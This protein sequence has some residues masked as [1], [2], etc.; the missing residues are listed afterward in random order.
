MSDPETV[1]YE[2]VED[3]MSARFG[4]AWARFDAQMQVGIPQIA[5]RDVWGKVTTKLGPV[6]SHDEVRHVPH[7]RYHV[8]Y[9]RCVFERGAH[10]LRI[11]IEGDRIAGMSMEHDRGVQ[12]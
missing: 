3:L 6:L 1:A 7:H 2:F 4:K 9:V 8:L 12:G 10:Q 5:L 11:A